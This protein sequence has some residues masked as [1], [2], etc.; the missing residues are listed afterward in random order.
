MPEVRMHERDT[1]H[2]R[3][4][5]DEERQEFENDVIHQET[6]EPQPSGPAS[7]PDIRDRPT[8]SIPMP[9]AQNPD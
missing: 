4:M 1:T 7:E 9:I 3:D 6:R 5:T 8:E 2:E